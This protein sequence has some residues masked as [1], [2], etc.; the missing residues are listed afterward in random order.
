MTALPYKYQNFNVMA[1]AWAM[2][3]E[4][5]RRFG[6]ST[7]RA[8]LRTAWFDHKKR[9]KMQADINTPSLSWEEM[10]DQHYRAAFSK[11]TRE[12]MLVRRNLLKAE[13]E[14]I[15]FTHQRPTPRYR[16]LDIEVARIDRYL[17]YAKA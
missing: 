13:M 6:D 17:P 9:L 7:F 12:D 1:A 8:C 16:D 5:T 14:D 4:L 11:R 15:Y 3:R 10:E 2:H